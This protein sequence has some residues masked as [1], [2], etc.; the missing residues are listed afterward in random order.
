[1]IYSA[2]LSLL[3][4]LISPAKD[5]NKVVS[6]K[7]WRPLD[8]QPI[9]WVGQRGQELQIEPSFAGNQQVLSLE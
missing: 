5:K 4:R 1:M 2:A 3:W 9:F 6:L 8:K 7:L